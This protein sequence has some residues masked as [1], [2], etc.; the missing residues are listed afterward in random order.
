MH[1]A[2]EKARLRRLAEETEREA[3]AERARQ[4]ARELAER[5]GSKPPSAAAAPAG[6]TSVPPPGLAKPGAPPGLEKAAPQITIAARPKPVE[7]ALDAGPAAPADA[8]QSWRRSG[9]LPESRGA[10]GRRPSNDQRGDVPH[11]LRRAQ[12]Q[13]DVPPHV[14]PVPISP[15]KAVGQHDHIAAPVPQSSKREANFD[16]MLARLQAAMHHARVSPPPGME[17]AAKQQEG[18]EGDVVSTEEDSPRPQV[19]EAPKPKPKPQHFAHLPPEYFAATQLEI[20]KSPPPAW[21]IYTVKLPSVQPENRG[22]IPRWRIKLAESART[23]AP[24]GWWMTYVPPIANLPPSQSLADLLLPQPIGRRFA[25]QV[26]TGPIISISP[27]QL[28]PFERKTKRRP[29]LESRPEGPP[30]APVAELSQTEPALHTAQDPLLSQGPGRLAMVNTRL[31]APQPTADKAPV[32]FMV[33]SEL[34]G[35]S[36]L[37]EVNKM[38]LEHIGE[39]EDKGAAKSAEPKKPLTPPPAA[40]S[41]TLN[42]ASPNAEQGPWAKSTLAYNLTSPGRGDARSDVQQRERVK[43]VWEQSSSEATAKAAAPASQPDTPLYPSLNSPAVSHE[44]QAPKGGYAMSQQSSASAFGSRS[45]FSQAGAAYG[46]FRGSGTTSPDA[47]YGLNRNGGTGSANGFQPGL[48]APAV[49]FGNSMASPGYGYKGMEKN[50]G[51]LNKD[52]AAYSDASFR[53]G[54]YQQQGQAYNGFPQGPQGQYRSPTYNYGQHGFGT[55]MAGRT[56]SAG[57]GR[58]MN[59]EYQPGVMYDGYYQG[60]YEGFSPSQ[61]HGQA[62]GGGGGGGAA[63]LGRVGRKMW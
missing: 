15:V 58:F 11:D 9:P 25:K 43:S 31:G 22:S 13:R 62:G 2:A 6:S 41:Q 18:V 40:S 34:D 7:S 46:Q 36:L 33:S 17:R 52:A 37:E 28:L 21:R 4:K 39:G 24:K 14:V 61:S 29:T 23:S 56:G 49:G 32:R 47:S 45:S 19:A 27:R 59:G 48:W 3:A 38:S 50:A 53:Y 26:D 35:D 63:G 55:Q 8:A 30:S 60:S 10:K 5:F 12:A 51:G 20:P 54:N 44:V 57:G 16:T 1:S 42:V